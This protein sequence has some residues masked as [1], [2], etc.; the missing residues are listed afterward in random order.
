[1]REKFAFN[2]T[3]LF[4][5]YLSKE[6]LGEDLPEVKR[7]L[8]GH[9]DKDVSSESALTAGHYL[10]WLLATKEELTPDRLIRMT[11]E[12]LKDGHSY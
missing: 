8:Y 9:R 2:H 10:L 5:G 11:K 3:G 1:M 12:E 6:V 7:H 4:D